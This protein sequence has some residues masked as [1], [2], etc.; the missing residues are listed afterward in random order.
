[1]PR[2]VFC[3]TQKAV[4]PLEGDLED[5]AFGM[6]KY[7]NGMIVLIHTSWTQWKN[8]F[9]FEIFGTKGSIEVQGL[10]GSYGQETLIL[11]TRN[12]LGGAPK[13]EKI[14]FE[15]SDNSWSLEWQDF[16][17]GISEGYPYHG[18]PVDGVGAMKIIDAM[19]RSNKLN[20]PLKI[21]ESK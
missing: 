10:G 14:F 16:M 5:N 19:Y 9:Q 18:T 4:W 21:Y 6:L 13:T 20:M 11:N 8:K 3:W 7:K 15:V 2:Q 12:P 17:A 1:M